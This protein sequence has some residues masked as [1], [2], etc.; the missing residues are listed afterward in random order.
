MGRLTELFHTIKNGFSEP[1]QYHWL[2]MRDESIRN[3]VKIMRKLAKKPSQGTEP[4][5]FEQAEV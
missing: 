1:E 3:T 2:E 4:T 5:L